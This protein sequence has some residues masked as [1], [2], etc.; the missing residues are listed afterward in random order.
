MFKRD[1]GLQ[2]RVSEKPVPRRSR[3]ANGFWVK[4]WKDVGRRGRRRVAVMPGPPGRKVM[5]EGVWDLEERGMLRVVKKRD[6]VS[7]SGLV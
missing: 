3:R 2:M 6:S 5:A 4:G 1:I 7:R